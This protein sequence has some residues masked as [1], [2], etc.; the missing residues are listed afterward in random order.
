MSFEVA[1]GQAVPAQEYS[2]DSSRRLALASYSLSLLA[3]RRDTQLWPGV[4]GQLLWAGIGAPE[5]LQH[6]LRRDNCAGEA[7]RHMFGALQG[8]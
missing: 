4:L 6:V 3:R 2:V 1:S 5:R 8:M 7:F